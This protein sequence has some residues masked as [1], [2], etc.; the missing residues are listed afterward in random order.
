MYLIDERVSLRLHHKCKSHAL[1]YNFILISCTM[2]IAY[3]KK[4]DKKEDF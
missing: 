2:Y 4:I 3:S 1:F